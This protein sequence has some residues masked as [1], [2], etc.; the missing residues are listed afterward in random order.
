[1]SENDTQRGIPAYDPCNADL[2][3]TM[4]DKIINVVAALI[5]D[6]TGRV[7]LVRK[8]G[9]TAFMQPGGKPNTGEGNV[10]ALSREVTEELGCCIDQHS[11]CAV[12]VFECAAA[13]EP[14]F[15]VRAVVYAVEIEGTATPQAEVD[16]LVWVDP[17]APPDIPF[18][19]LA[20]PCAAACRTVNQFGT[21]R[22]HA[23]SHRACLHPNLDRVCQYD[24]ASAHVPAGSRQSRR[25]CGRTWRATSRWKRT[26]RGPDLDRLPQTS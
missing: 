7:L 20:R 13:N 22:K 5:R 12:G 25:A 9:T 18:A 3:S 15:M 24:L 19:P 14:G 2:E 23:V 26:S 1:M 4:D 16:Q 11:A 8:R 21:P 6:S 17:K 10:A